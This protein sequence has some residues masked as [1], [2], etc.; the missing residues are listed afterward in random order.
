MANVD[1]VIIKE[2]HL[3]YLQEKIKHRLTDKNAQQKSRPIGTP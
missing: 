3:G 2:Q 1:Y